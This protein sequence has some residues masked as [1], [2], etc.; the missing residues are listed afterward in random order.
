MKVPLHFDV[1]VA[2]RAARKCGAG[3]GTEC[4]GHLRLD[5]LSQL[6][7]KCLE[8]NEFPCILTL[9]ILL[10]LVGQHGILVVNMGFV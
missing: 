4:I 8:C 10:I 5:V 3:F 1:G 7:R 6:C 9:A 2:V